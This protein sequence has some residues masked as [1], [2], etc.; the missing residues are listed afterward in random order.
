MA[1]DAWLEIL[2]KESNCTLWI[3]KTGKYKIKMLLQTLARAFIC[4]SA[5]RK[6]G[7]KAH[8]C[9]Q[10]VCLTP[11]TRRRRG[12]HRGKK[13]IKKQKQSKARKRG[14]V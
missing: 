12:Q 8:T 5:H 13:N 7:T 9:T 14:E 10:Q 3:W 11:M 1:R 2:V 4:S 6:A